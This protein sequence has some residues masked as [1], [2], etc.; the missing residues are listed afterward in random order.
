MSKKYPPLTPKQICKILK[1]HNFQHTDNR[2]DH[3]IYEKGHHHVEVDMGERDFRTSGMQIIIHNSSL[4]REAF[5][6]A[7]KEAAKK[8]G[9]S[10]KR[11]TS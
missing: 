2:G 5:Y 1:R 3:R 4:S 6:S 10:Y 9:V 7:I 11:P 8:I